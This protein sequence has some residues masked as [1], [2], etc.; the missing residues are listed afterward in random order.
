MVSVKN[1]NLIY[2]ELNMITEGILG[3]IG[4][5]FLYVFGQFLLPDEHT[6]IQQELIKFEEE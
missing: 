5:I 2:G 4:I 6:P 1:T 3:F